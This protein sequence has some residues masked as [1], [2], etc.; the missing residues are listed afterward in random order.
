MKHIVS[1]VC[2]R[3]C[4]WWNCKTDGGCV[5]NIKSY[6]SYRCS[7]FTVNNIMYFIICQ[8]CVHILFVNK[9]YW[10]LVV[11]HFSVQH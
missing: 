10:E 11:N 2:G 7:K 5:R 9:L 4:W 8:V 6:R 1:L 3:F